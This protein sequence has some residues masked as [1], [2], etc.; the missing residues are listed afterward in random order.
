[1]TISTTTSRVSYD[2]DGV[3]VSFPVTFLFL[4]NSHIVVTLRVDSTGVETTWVENTQYTLTGAGVAAGGTLTIDTSP[5]DYTP[6]T[7][8]TLVIRRV[9]P[10]TQL[11]DYPEGGAFPAS[12][13]ETAL[14]KQLESM[15]EEA[16]ETGNA[17]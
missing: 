13:H 2:G 10:A 12:S 15:G 14:D 9:V 17:P 11:T 16:A 5:T 8:E 6:A 7:G 4:A 3:T 1:M